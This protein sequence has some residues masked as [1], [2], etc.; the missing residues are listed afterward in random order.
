MLFVKILLLLLALLILAGL[1]AA[2]VIFLG[3]YPFNLRPDLSKIKPL[4]NKVVL[5]SSDMTNGVFNIAKK[6]PDGSFSDDFKILGFTDLHFDGLNERIQ[7]TYKWMCY[8]IEKEK[9]DM[10][11]ILGDT[12]LCYGNRTRTKEVAEIMKA[13]GV[14]WS[15]VLG[16][17]EGESRLELSRRNTMALY[18]SYENCLVAVS[19]KGV[20]GFG[21]TVVNIMSSEKEIAQ[22]LYFMDSGGENNIKHIQ[23]SQVEWYERT[24]KATLAKDPDTKSMIFMHIPIYKYKEACEKVNN[25][26]LRFIWGEQHESVCSGKSDEEDSFIFQK[27]L[28]LGS[29]KLF[30][31]GHDHLNDFGLDYQGIRLMYNQPSGYSCYDR[32]STTLKRD[33]TVTEEIRIQGCTVYTIHNDKTVSVESKMNR[34]AAVNTVQ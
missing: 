7:D 3:V 28:E 23:P 1:I 8:N 9:P 15:I 6:N 16:N 34:N 12:A 25:G 29:T 31:S 11:V 22:S 33:P 19:V 17:H 30:S 24:L 20:H 4:D 14:Y 26:E 2:G 5:L 10:V 13:Y 27:A 18:A 32:Y 21:N